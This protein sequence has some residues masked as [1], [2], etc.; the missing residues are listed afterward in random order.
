MSC[1]TGVEGLIC[2]D[3]VCSVTEG[4]TSDG[5]GIVVFLGNLVPSYHVP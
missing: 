2:R 3:N 5:A 1:V 4:Q